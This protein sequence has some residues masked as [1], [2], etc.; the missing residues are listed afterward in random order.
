M[1]KPSIIVIGVTEETA[2]YQLFVIEG[3]KIVYK[4]ECYL[5]NLYD[6]D[7]SKVPVLEVI[8]KLGIK[9]YGEVSRNAALVNNNMILEAV[10]TV[11]PEFNPINIIIM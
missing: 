11:H 9:E 8:Y 3:A 7:Y 6:E 4:E 1:E 5:Y 2:H 10:T